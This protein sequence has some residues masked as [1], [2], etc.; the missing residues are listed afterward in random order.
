M[1]CYMMAGMTSRANGLGGNVELFLHQM[2]PHHINAVNMAKALLNT[3]VLNC[4]DLSEDT[5]DCTLEGILWGILNNQ[6]YQIQL[7]YGVLKD[8]GLPSSNDCVIGI[9]QS[10]PNTRTVTTPVPPSTLS[11]F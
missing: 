9:P 7:M 6:N 3:K 11:P 1:N 10:N 8:G 4:P 2:I 5:D